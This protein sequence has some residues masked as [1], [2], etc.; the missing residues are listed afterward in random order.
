MLRLC[1]PLFT[2][3]GA[4]ALDQ[5]LARC[6]STELITFA[7]GEVPATIT[8]AVHVLEAIAAWD[9]N[10]N[11]RVSCAEARAHGIAPV[12]RDHPAYPF[13]R[14]GDGDGDGDGVVCESGRRRASPTSPPTSPRASGAGCG[15]YR[16]CTALR[17]DHPNGVSRGHC[18][19][20]R[21]MDRDNDGRACER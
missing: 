2:R 9:D 5:V 21:R 6:A 17:R 3:S 4:D 19:Y 11:G 16:N 10:Q 8:A 20:Q 7:R 1:R 14:A 18:A 15:P 12:T 13:M